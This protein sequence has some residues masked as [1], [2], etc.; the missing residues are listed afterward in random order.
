MTNTAR[1]PDATKKVAIIGG[2]KSRTQAP[3]HDPSWDIWAFSSLRLHTPRITR[4]FEM[5]ALGDLKG[6]LRRE[7]RYRRSFSSYM[8]FLSHLDRPVYMQRTHKAIPKSVKYP[9]RAALRNFGK[10]FTSTASYLIALAIMEGYGTIGVWGVH[11]VA[12]RVYTRQRPEIEYLLGVAK[13]R[14]IKV[15]LPAGCPLRIPTK[16][17]FVPTDILYGYDW[18]SPKAWWRKKRTERA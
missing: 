17:V 12:R 16:P 7:T 18:Q 1:N 9:I 8:R 6:Q 15:Y 10:C 3:Y 14:G 5:H 4:W 2:A 13:R 11:L